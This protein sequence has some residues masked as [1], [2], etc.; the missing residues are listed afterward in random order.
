[1]D[2]DT[3]VLRAAA[4]HVQAEVGDCTDLTRFDG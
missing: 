4:D 3:T 1:M 2:L